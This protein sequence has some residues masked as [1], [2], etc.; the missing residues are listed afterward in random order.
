MI[1]G[2]R[3][4]DEDWSLYNAAIRQRLGLDRPP[5]RPL[6][7][8][9]LARA[10]RV[11]AAVLLLFGLLSALSALTWQ[12]APDGGRANPFAAW[13]TQPPTPNPAEGGAPVVT[14]Y[15]LFHRVAH[16]PGMSVVTGWRFASS[17]DRGPA[18]QFCYLELPTDG[19]ADRQVSVASRPT[20]PIR[21]LPPAA[22]EAGLDAMGW[23]AVH[24]KC[25]WFSG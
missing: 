4:L 17:G 8:R 22:A 20:E 1:P 12:P 25:N 7:R 9:L 10:I 23:E 2:R 24:R 18:N 15:V 14:N 13:M 5:P 6:W 16:E 21:P 11:A 19:T 3:D